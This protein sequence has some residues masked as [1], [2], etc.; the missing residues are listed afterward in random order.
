MSNNIS[1][2]KTKIANIFIPWIFALASIGFTFTRCFNNTFEDFL[3]WT[4]LDYYFPN[5]THRRVQDDNFSEMEDPVDPI[6]AEDWIFLSSYMNDAMREFLSL[7]RL[8]A[9]AVM[10][11]YIGDSSAV[12]YLMENLA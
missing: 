12:C 11:G 1:V 8:R 3:H 6:E 2:K 7:H 5:A 9:E 10:Q 4:L